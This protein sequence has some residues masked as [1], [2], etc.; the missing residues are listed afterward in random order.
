M[1]D[2]TPWQ[3]LVPAG[4][5]PVHERDPADQPTAFDAT[6]GGA[7]APLGAAHAQVYLVVRQPAGV[8]V[9]EVKDGQEL[10][11]GRGPEAAVRVEEPRVSR[12]H[13]VLRRDGARLVV[14]DLGSRNGTKLNGRRF[15]G[16][17]VDVRGGDV[18]RV[19]SADAIVAVAEGTGPAVASALPGG[20]LDAELARI[21]R[22][23]RPA[24]TLVRIGVESDEGAEGLQALAASLAGATLVEEVANDEYAVLLEAGDPIL[25][26]QSLAALRARPGLRIGV[27]RFPHDGT[28]AAELW[29]RARAAARPA[30]PQGLSERVVVA[31]AAMVE[32]YSLARRLAAVQT[33]VLI[34]GE[35]GVGKEVLAEQ[36]HRW[37][38]R[39]RGPFV[40]LNCASLPE[41][42]LESELFGHERGAFTGAERKKIGYLEA[43]HGGTLLLDEVGELPLGMQVKLLNVLESRVV[44][45]VGSTQ[46]IPID[47]RVLAATH[48][49][50]EDE[51][52]RGRFREDLYY[53]LSAFK[54]QVPPLRER[55]TEVA[56]LADA[57][58]RQLA[59]QS[60]L[61]APAIGVEAFRALGAYPWP[62]NVRELRNAVEHAVVLAESGRIEPAHL[63][64]SVRDHGTPS[65]RARAGSV[66]DRMEELERRSIEEALA[67]ESGNK[68]RAARRLGLSRRA[69]IYKLDKYGLRRP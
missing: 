31:D 30:A 46:P 8:E 63:P 20:R 33:T 43:A 36:I 61:P 65:A 56:L 62:G 2:P 28:S 3:P 48:R 25:V 44:A 58:V 45:R 47:V 4:R 50:L 27:V 52:A 39:A 18:I 24:A 17:P 69:L 66:R 9:V 35:T 67:A 57:F 60:G 41:T 22:T 68:T 29:S 38:P 55:P 32:V 11:F 10:L 19:G 42:L 12:Q 7:D 14:E 15:R 59:A 1:Q 54:L 40:R 5:L 16:A 34:L 53:R 21:G 64:A 13:A 6:E 26:E 49:D 23:P 37:S 51:V